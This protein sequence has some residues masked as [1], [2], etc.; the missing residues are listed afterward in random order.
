MANIFT[1]YHRYPPHLTINFDEPNW[2]LLMADDQMLALRGAETVCH[3]C[4]SDAKANFSF[5]AII[6]ADGS[7]LPLVL[8]TKG[9]T[10]RCHKQLGRHDSYIY[11]VLHSPSGWSTV[12]LMIQYL[13]WPRAQI[14]GAPFCLVMDQRTTHT[15]PKIGEEA[16]ELGIKIIWVR[17]SGTG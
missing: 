13:K 9:K 16:E 3:Y 2:H 14:P 15:A 10:D 6:T 12:S 5:L 4:E 7:K 17:K 8:I 1:A 11:D